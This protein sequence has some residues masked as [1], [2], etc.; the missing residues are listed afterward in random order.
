MVRVIVVEVEVTVLDVVD[1]I[2]AVLDSVE[3]LDSVSVTDEVEV[4]AASSRRLIAMACCEVTTSSAGGS[5]KVLTEE[6]MLH[7]GSLPSK[8]VQVPC[9]QTTASEEEDRPG[10]HLVLHICPL[11]ARL[12][13]DS[14][15]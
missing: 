9:L 10:S 15:L 3:V 1:D 14:K 11:K 12:H 6:S 8:P 4:V 2:V 5:E 7:S 13:V